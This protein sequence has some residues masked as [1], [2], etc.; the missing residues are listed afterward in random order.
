MMTKRNSTTRLFA[1][2]GIA[3]ALI[4]AAGCRSDAAQDAGQ[5]QGP[6]PAPQVSVAEVVSKEVRNWDE[7]TGRVEAVES[8][9]IRPRVSGYI[10]EVRYTEG[11]EV[12]KGDV[13]FVIDQRPYRAELARVEAELAR[14][15]AQ[16]ELARSEMNRARKLLETRAISQEEHDQRI[17]IASQTQAGVAAAEAALETARLNMQFTEVRSPISGRTGRAWVTAG[18][19]VNSG[20]TI[21]TTVVSLDPVHVYFEGDERIQQ[22]YSQTA[23]RGDGRNPVMVGLSNEQGFPHEGYLDFVDNEVDTSTG[24]LR[25]RAVLDNPNRIFTPGVFARVKLIGNESF[26]ALLV[27]ERA[28]LT[29]QDRRYVY[30]LGPDNTAQRRDV[31]PGRLVDGLRV[32]REGLA[33]GDRV[34]VHGVQK[35]FFPGMVVD[36]QPIAMGDPA[37]MP[38]APQSAA[39]TADAEGA[40]Q[41]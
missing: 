19:L 11:A 40:P 27:D 4:A 26:D 5:E 22:R 8:V 34:I 3:A 25:G 24:T 10:D 14:A 36:P 12:A 41:S 39:E 35:V 38:G 6:P 33:A 32:I 21:L 29:D 23:R 17:A 13:L 37:P 30:V 9:E 15:R 2:A 16:Y 20:E 18:N 7:F 1:A 31:Q 28:I